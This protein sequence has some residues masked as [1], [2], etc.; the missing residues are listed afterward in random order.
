MYAIII[1]FLNQIGKGNFNFH[2]MPSYGSHDRTRAVGT[3]HS[4]I[5]NNMQDLLALGRMKTGFQ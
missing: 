5:N 2:E 3:L 1:I 4:A